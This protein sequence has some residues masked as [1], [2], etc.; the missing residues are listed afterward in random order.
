M[1]SL[2]VVDARC[3][4]DLLFNG[5][6]ALDVLEVISGRPL[7][8]P[9]HIDLDVVSTLALLNPSEVPAAD[10]R[11]RVEFY[12][13]MPMKRHD[14]SALILDALTI[15]DRHGGLCVND[16]LYVALAD[17]L[18]VPLVTRSRAMAASCSRAILV[19]VSRG[20]GGA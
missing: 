2:A 5:R 18:E 12:L 14:V 1:A 11:M 4:V 3:V 10:I 16:A 7:A 19:Q 15:G 20:W 6:R 13:R 9:A 8:A 17:H